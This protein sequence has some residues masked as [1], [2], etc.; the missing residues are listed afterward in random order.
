MNTLQKRFNLIK[1]EYEEKAL[2]ISESG[3]CLSQI[4]GTDENNETVISYQIKNTLGEILDEIPLLST[5]ERMIKNSKKLKI[6]LPEQ[7]S[8]CS[9]PY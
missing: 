5:I 8:K 2:S 3:L 7:M 6:I 4:I 9:C 1:E